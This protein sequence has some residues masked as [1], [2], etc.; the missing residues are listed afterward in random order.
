MYQIP[1]KVIPRC[2]IQV[3]ITRQTLMIS[4]LRKCTVFK[5]MQNQKL[6]N[7]DSSPVIRHIHLILSQTHHNKH[8]ITTQKETKFDG[9]VCVSFYLF[10]TTLY[11]GVFFALWGIYI[12]S[13]NVTYQFT[14][15][16]SPYRCYHQQLLYYNKFRSRYLA[17]VNNANKLPT[18][19]L[20]LHVH[21]SRFVCEQKTKLNICWNGGFQFLFTLLLTHQPCF[22]VRVCNTVEYSIYCIIF[23]SIS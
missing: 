14:F 6:L 21:C 11:L 12:Q 22:L 10:L 17:E 19:D 4:S 2:N 23:S 3:I 20:T 5:I 8:C 1:M 9:V 13:Y 7:D 15:I 16:T 18:F